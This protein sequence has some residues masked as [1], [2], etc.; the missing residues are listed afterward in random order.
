MNITNM[1]IGFVIV[2]A[3]VRMYSIYQPKSK[4]SLHIALMSL[5]TGI[6]FLTGFSASSFWVALVQL[7]LATVILFCCEEA[8]K[9]EY[10]E[11][12]REMKRKK[13][14]SI[15]KARQLQDMGYMPKQR[16]ARAC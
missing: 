4:D 15:A 12:K 1:I 9:K 3:T 14:I 6:I 8:L 7:A 13:A 10:L 16:S 11:R 2:S 5:G